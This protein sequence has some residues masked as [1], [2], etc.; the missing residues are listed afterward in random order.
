MTRKGRDLT[1]C[2]ECDCPIRP[3]NLEGHLRRVH[4]IGAGEVEEE[5][6]S[7]S[8]ERKELMLRRK[9]LKMNIG[10]SVVVIVLLA[11]G[12]Y[13]G[14][15]GDDNG[16]TPYTFSST[17]DIPG[18]TAGGDVKIP[19][20]QITRKAKF[21]PYKSGG[22]SIRFFAVEGSDGDVHVAFDACDVCYSERKGYRQKEDMMSCNNCGQEFG[23]NSIGTENIK[24]GCWPSYLPI[25]VSGDE[26]LVRKDDILSKKYMFG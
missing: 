20:S 23:I 3:S 8:E 24:G 19:F 14:L 12:I 18:R 1:S 6:R 5:T 25:E 16:D 11:I 21:Y 2:P 10:F 22:V 26:V 17:E 9:K 4:G 7:R 13:V 15:F